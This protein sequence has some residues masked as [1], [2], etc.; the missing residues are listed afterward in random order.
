MFT[1][2]Y[3]LCFSPPFPAPLPRGRQ[4][5]PFHLAQVHGNKWTT[6]AS[7]LSLLVISAGTGETPFQG[8]PRDRVL[9]LSGNAN[10]TAKS[11][12]VGSALTQVLVVNIKKTQAKSQSAVP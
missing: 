7:A 11:L 6:L 1:R 4:L 2:V 5:P 10:A 12:Y 9:I 3:V 8:K